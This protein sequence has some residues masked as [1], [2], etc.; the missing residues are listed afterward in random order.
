MSTVPETAQAIRIQKN[1]GTE[2]LEK[3]QV[4]LKQSAG[5][6]VVKVEYFGVNFI[7]TYHRA[8]LYKVPLPTTIGKEASGT[9]IG[10]PTDEETLNNEIF[11]KRGYRIGTKV[12]VDVFGAHQDHISV[13]WKTV[14]PVPDDIPLNVASAALLQ[15]LTV[16]SFIEES[17]NVQ[18]GDIILVHT[19]A[20]GL[21]LIFAQL[22]SARGATV[23]GTTSTPEKAEL[24]KKNGAHHV[25]LYK[26]ENVVERVLEITKG[27]G[28]HAI[29]DGVGKDTFEDDF[30][31]IRRKG[32]LVSL[33]NASGAV[34]PFSPLKLVEKNVK[35]LRPT[36]AN[37]TVTAEECDYYNAKLWPLI[38]NGTLK[39][40]IF[41]EYP[42]TVEGYAQ[43]QN[44][45]VGGK[46]TGKV[47]ID[48]NKVE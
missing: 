28:V 18:K 47:I 38:K 10:L 29:F 41:K 45:L 3:L 33:G 20:G 43:A 30:K 24:A 6:V 37:Y 23:I 42:F 39:M 11:K 35:L 46:T 8:G 21:G 5:E 36:Q 13:P 31:M 27:Q 34:P 22:I 9:I 44:D 12:A 19:I 32:T 14:Y 1:G 25:I 7:D 17:Y 26:N 48:L 40:N 4:P 2:V 16:L 15:S